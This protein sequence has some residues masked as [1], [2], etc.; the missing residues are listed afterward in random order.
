[1]QK[2]QTLETMDEVFSD[3]VWILGFG[4]IFYSGD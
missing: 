1:L 3:M 2:L 4:I